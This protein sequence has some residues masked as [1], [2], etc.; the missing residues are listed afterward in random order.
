MLLQSI[1]GRRK[2]AQTIKPLNP[3]AMMQ[4]AM[5][6]PKYHANLLKVTQETLKL[7]EEELPHVQKLIADLES[8]KSVW[9]LPILMHNVVL[10]GRSKRRE[11]LSGIS[12]LLNSIA[13]EVKAANKP[14]LTDNYKYL[15]KTLKDV[16]ENDTHPHIV[17][18]DLSTFLT[19]FYTY[20][21]NEAK[22]PLTKDETATLN[23]LH[24]T[25]LSIMRRTKT[26]KEET[27]EKCKQII[28]DL[29]KESGLEQ[30]K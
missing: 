10:L 13:K 3:A 27:I 26:E 16:D 15:I 14:E 29:E 19:A 5:K 11:M 30:S 25:M 9:E 4:K 22:R 28:A 12:T 21:L 18:Y 2:K 20:V 1:L 6:S 24:T 8:C 7:N 23:G 17:Y